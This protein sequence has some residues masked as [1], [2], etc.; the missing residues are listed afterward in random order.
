M[1]T[2]QFFSSDPSLQSLIPLHRASCGRHRS[3]PPHLC[4]SSRHSDP[5][6]LE[7]HLWFFKEKLLP[8]CNFSTNCKSIN[9]CTEWIVDHSK[10]RKAYCNRKFH[11][12]CPG[13]GRFHRRA[14]RHSG[15]SDFAKSHPS[16]KRMETGR[17]Q[18]ERQFDYR[19]LGLDSNRARSK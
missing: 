14:V 4:S 9:Y 7:H 2:S 10:R 8:I 13:N 1:Q 15:R 5:V 18:T 12:T 17:L 16:G 6:K 11:Q 3:C 19:N